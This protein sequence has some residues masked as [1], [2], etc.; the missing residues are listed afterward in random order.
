MLLMAHA[1][2]SR[3]SFHYLAKYNIF[4]PTNENLINCKSFYIDCQTLHCQRCT[5]AH[6][7]LFKIYY[8]ASLSGTIPPVAPFYICVCVCSCNCFKAFACKWQNIIHSIMHCLHL[9]P[10]L[11]WYIVTKWAATV[12]MTAVQIGIS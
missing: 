5:M 10:L 4:Y 3:T 1:A 8:D 2:S 7:Q 6:L 11:T 12:T 9:P